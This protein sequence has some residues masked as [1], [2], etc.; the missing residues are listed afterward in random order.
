[1]DTIAPLPSSPS[2]PSHTETTPYRPSTAGWLGVRGSSTARR[3]S[4]PLQHVWDPTSSERGGSHTSR[5]GTAT[6]TATVRYASYK[7]R[8]GGERKR[9]RLSDL[10]PR[11]V[12]S[13]GVLE[14]VRAEDDAHERHGKGKGVASK[15]VMLFAGMEFAKKALGGEGGGRSP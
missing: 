3:F 1:M 8:G 13:G 9:P 12:T 10:S 6:S 15:F 11:P 4:M 7:R 14:S 5:P 2:S